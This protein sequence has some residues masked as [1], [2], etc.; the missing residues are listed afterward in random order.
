MKD[1]PY[2]YR[3]KEPVHPG[4]HLRFCIEEL[5]ISGRELAL[6]C[7]KPEKTISAILNG[8]SAIT[9][10][11]A[12]ALEPVLRS[13]A[14]FWLN[15]QKQYEE[16]IARQKRELNLQPSAENTAWAKQFDYNG[17]AKAGAVPVTRK[18]QERLEALLI[19]IGISSPAAWD[20]FVKYRS[21]VLLSQARKTGRASEANLEAWLAFGMQRAQTLWCGT[22]DAKAFQ[23][24]IDGLRDVMAEADE[25]CWER[26][27]SDCLKAGVKVVF[28]P[29]IKGVPIQGAVHWVAETPVI[30]LS[31]EGKGYGKTWQAFLYEAAHVLLH[32]KKSFLD[33]IVRPKKKG[34]AGRDDYRVRAADQWADHWLVAE[35]E[36]QQWGKPS[37]CADVQRM[38]DDLKTHPDVLLTRME[39]NGDEIRPQWE[40][41]RKN[42]P[43]PK[44]T[45]KGY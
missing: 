1:K 43:K 22:F 24:A 4:T 6:R 21:K 31:S 14:N 2:H 8:K 28:T 25:Q 13:P 15:G 26:I 27:A 18:R 7:K 3:P 11:M 9:F 17:L 45:E 34:E 16:A 44:P 5:G 10:D 29:P 32:P 19:L 41:L 36:M 35:P 38:A 39:R 12:L 20:G 30:Q 42:L 37:T 33:P 40:A 23:L